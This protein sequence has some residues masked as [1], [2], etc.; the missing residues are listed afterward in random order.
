MPQNHSPYSQRSHQDWDSRPEQ[1]PFGVVGPTSAAG[2]GRTTTKASAAL[3]EE[4]NIPIGI[5]SGIGSACLEEEKK[6]TTGIGAACLEEEKK[7][8]TAIGS[9][10]F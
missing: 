6:I 5:V 9:A 4:G 7:I 2:S 10:C 1:W 8:A 3:L